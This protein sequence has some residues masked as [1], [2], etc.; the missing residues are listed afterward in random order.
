[1]E[2]INAITHTEGAR[3]LGVLDDTIETLTIVFLN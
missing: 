3:I 2:T 1:M